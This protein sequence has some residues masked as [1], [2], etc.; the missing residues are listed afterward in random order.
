M[1]DMSASAQEA[2]EL[3]R[4]L[5]N[6]T[7][8]MILCQLAEGEQSVGNLARELGARQTA[9]SQQLALLRRDGV[10]TPRREGQ[11][12]FYSL[13]SDE[14]RRVIEAL[15]SIYCAPKKKKGGNRKT[16]TRSPRSASD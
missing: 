6:E 11:T 3:M 15:Y 8:L 7:R 2:A 4:V 10:V 9:V 16:P 13:A 12:I 14:V 1:Q 5:G